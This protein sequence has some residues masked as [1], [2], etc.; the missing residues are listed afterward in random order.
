MKTI[1]V[2]PIKL[3]SE[4]CKNKN[5]KRFTKG[6]PLVYYILNTLLRVR[7]LDEIYVYCSSEE[8]ISLLPPQVKFIKRDEYYDLPNV[9]FNDVLISFAKIVDA[10]TY[11][12]AHATSPFIT[13]DSIERGIQAVNEDAYDSAFTV[14]RSN[15]FIWK[16]GKPLNYCLEN[17]PRTQDL[18]EILIETCGL[19]VYTK[20]LLLTRHRR[21]GDNPFFIYVS[22]IEGWDINSDEDFKIADAINCHLNKNY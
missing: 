12:L 15:D 21:I 20:N 10:D 19:Y 5:I 11:V 17:I 3:N 9:S 6:M 22:K 1:A 8:I 18:D 16:D 13:P 4:R 14:V 2:V 7:K